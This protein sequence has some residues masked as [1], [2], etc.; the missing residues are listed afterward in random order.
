MSKLDAAG[1]PTTKRSVQ[2]DLNTLSSIFPL[3]SDT[4]TIPFGWSWSTAAEAF[5]LPAMDGPTALTF[6][7]IEQFIP[8]LLPPS[9]HDYL[10]PQ[11]A[12]AKATLDASPKSP[13]G[14]WADCVRVVPR[15]M[16]L[17]PPKYD[18][19][20]VR[21]VYEALLAGKRLIAEYRSRSAA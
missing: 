7:M 9:I 2:R 15:E 1:Y 3:E 20:A 17:L 16:P 11:F 14:H 19:N 21:V 4:R 13:L 18:V 6:R 10:A 5:D 12:R 8:V